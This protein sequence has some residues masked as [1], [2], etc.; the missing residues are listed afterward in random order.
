LAK[1][2]VIDYGGMFL[3]FFGVGLII[4]GL[5]W[6]GVVYPW[7][8]TAVLAPLIIGCILFLS[9]FAY[10]FL[11]TPGRALSRMFPSQ[12]LMIPLSLFKSRDM[13]LL[14]Y[15]N[16]STGMALFSVF[17]FVGIWFTIVQ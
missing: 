8:S 7:K 13:A 14:I 4:L 16:F 10:E 2:S 17:Y 6:A 11:L 3:F 9:F 1:F 12:A 5:T 15:L